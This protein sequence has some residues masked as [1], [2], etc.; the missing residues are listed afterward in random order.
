LAAKLHLCQ[1]ILRVEAEVK[2]RRD[3]KRVAAQPGVPAWHIAADV[4][5]WKRALVVMRFQ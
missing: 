3:A 5:A 1:V 4:T 2:L